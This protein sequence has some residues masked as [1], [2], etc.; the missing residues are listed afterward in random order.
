MEFE[1]YIIDSIIFLGLPT[2]NI[3][4]AMMVNLV[5]IVGSHEL[6]QTV[7]DHSDHKEGT[8]DK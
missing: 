4:I 8:L 5:N 6:F 3:T 1:R 7:G 2:Q